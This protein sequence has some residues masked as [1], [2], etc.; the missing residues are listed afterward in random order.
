MI[1]IL[2]YRIIEPDNNKTI[3]QFLQE[4]GYSRNVIIH[5]KKTPDSILKNDIW[6]YVNEPLYTGD[7]L[8]ITIIE[9]EGSPKIVPIELPLPIV[10]E[11]ED[12]L[13]VNKPADMPVHPSMNHYENTLANAVMWYFSNQGIAYTFRCINRLDRDTT[14]LTI[15]AKNMLSAG[16][17]SSFMQKHEIHKEYRAI[18]EGIVPPYGTINAP[19][20]RAGDSAIE[21]C[22]DPEHGEEAITHYICE[23][24]DGRHSL[25]KLI[26]D[27]GRT[28]QIR[29]HM[30]YLGHPLIGDFLYHPDD[31]T[32]SRQALHCCCLKFRHPITGEN[33][34]FEAPLP[35]DMQKILNE[36]TFL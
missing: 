14:G 23:K 15:L 5:L 36:G 25:V 19:I 35:E 10:Y 2:N 32:M 26:L 12:I 17:L 30:K 4:H 29:V 33:M 27:T 24:T 28:H 22:V 11:D 34:H 3:L 1:R 6:S 31:K 16:I 13:V 21:R 9:N 20:A 7:T 18:C 8:K